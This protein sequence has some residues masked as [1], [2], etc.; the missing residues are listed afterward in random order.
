MKLQSLG[1]NLYLDWSPD[2]NY[3]VTGNSTNHVIVWDVRTGN[4]LK[5]K[6]FNYEVNH[7]LSSYVIL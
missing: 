1:S 5:K 2:G 7:L 3:I 6:K 4:Q